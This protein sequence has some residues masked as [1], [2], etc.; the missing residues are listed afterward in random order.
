MPLQCARLSC[1]WTCAS[2]LLL[3][4][5]SEPTDIFVPEPDV[6]PSTGKALGTM[7]FFFPVELTFDGRSETCAKGASERPLGDDSVQ[8]AWRSGDLRFDYVLDQFGEALADDQWGD[9]ITINEAD[10]PRGDFLRG[11]MAV[12][13]QA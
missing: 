5:C 4:A 10:V 6:R 11:R 12:R 7:S 13:R 2:I 1:S 8:L 3:F 9:P